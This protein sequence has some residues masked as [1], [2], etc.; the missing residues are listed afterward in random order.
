MNKKI[1]FILTLCSTFL[2][3]QKVNAETNKYSYSYNYF[4]VTYDIYYDDTNKQVCV[5]NTCIDIKKSYFY[6][7]WQGTELTVVQSDQDNIIVHQENCPIPGTTNNTYFCSMNSNNNYDGF[8]TSTIGIQSLKITTIENFADLHYGVKGWN[9]LVSNVNLYNKDSSIYFSKNL[10][11]SINTTPTVEIIK[12]NETKVTISDKEY[13]KDVSLKMNFSIIDNEKYLYMYKY[14]EKS[15]WA[16]ITLT[17][18]DSFTVKYEYNDTLYVQIMDKSSKEIVSSSQFTISSIDKL[19][20]DYAYD[21]VDNDTINTS[22]GKNDVIFHKCTINLEVGYALCKIEFN[23]FDNDTYKYF[24]RVGDEAYT[25]VVPDSKTKVLPKVYDDSLLLNTND[26]ISLYKKWTDAEENPNQYLLPVTIYKN[27]TISVARENRSDNSVQYYTF[28]ITAF[29][30]NAELNQI[31]EFLNNVFFS[32]LGFIHQTKEIITN[33]FAFSFDE[34]AEPPIF[35]FDLSFINL[36]PVTVKME[37]DNSTR[38]LVH[39]L[40]KTFASI[41][42]LITFTKQMVNFANHQKEE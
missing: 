16:T 28:T 2:F 25:S 27:T 35:T 9:Q 5:S 11:V 10:D 26:D 23:N 7:F 6:F 3:F 1:M 20:D 22:P 42:L 34:N 18:S 41:F 19:P 31:L 13:I 37:I 40:I 39:S 30:E 32:K 36:K 33:F 8:L 15:E 14:G 4:G 24:Y 21:N 29:N 38:L 12:E 17:Q